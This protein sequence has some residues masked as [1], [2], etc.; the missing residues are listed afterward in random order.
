MPRKIAKIKEAAGEEVLA[1][2]SRINK[3]K[4]EPKNS[5]DADFRGIG[6]SDID[7]IL[8]IPGIDDMAG[9]FVRGNFKTD[10]ERI[11]Y[12]RVTRRLEKFKLISRLEFIRQCIS[13]KLGM[14]AFGK[15]L[16]LQ[17][18]I[19][20]IAPAVIREQLAMRRLKSKEEGVKGSDYRDETQSK[21]PREKE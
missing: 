6:E 11:A 9:V 10:E 5:F 17:S 12:L 20:L 16:Q 13:S 3:G 19:E 8:K 15:T 2:D 4:T 1:G 18:K 14:M 7:R 21:E